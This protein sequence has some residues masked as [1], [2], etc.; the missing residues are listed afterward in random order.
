MVPDDRFGERADDARGQANAYAVA[1]LGRL[2]TDHSGLDFFHAGY[3]L[4]LALSC[5]IPLTAIGE[6]LS[7]FTRSHRLTLA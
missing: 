5:L 7:F 1:L 2:L 6:R 4:L 3:A